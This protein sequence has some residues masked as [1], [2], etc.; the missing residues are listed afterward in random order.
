MASQP[1]SQPATQLASQPATQLKYA[2]NYHLFV[3][4]YKSSSTCFPLISVTAKRMNPHKNLDGYSPAMHTFNHLS[5]K[6]LDGYNR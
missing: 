4:I 3:M 2:G 1:A 6:K 5:R